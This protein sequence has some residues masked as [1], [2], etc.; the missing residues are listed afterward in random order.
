MTEA[1]DKLAEIDK[2]IADFTAQRRALAESVGQEIVSEVVAPILAYP[3]VSGWPG[4]S[5]HR[6]GTT[7]SRASSV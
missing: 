1:A 3:G 2:V 4:L 5:T 6:S 7:V